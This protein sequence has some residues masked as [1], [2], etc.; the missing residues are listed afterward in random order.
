MRIQ[1]SRRIYL[2]EFSFAY[3]DVASGTPVE[4]VTTCFSAGTTC[5]DPSVDG[6]IGDGRDSP[7]KYT[8]RS[9]GRFVA[10]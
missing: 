8:K 7:L 4:Q 5:S 3:N 10:C 1:F 2:R 9:D 6:V